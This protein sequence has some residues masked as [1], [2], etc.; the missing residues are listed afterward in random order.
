MHVS[1]SL[2]HGRSVGPSEQAEIWIRRSVF[3]EEL[4]PTYAG[5]L[6]YFTAPDGPP[7]AQVLAVNHAQAWLAEGITRLYIVEGVVTKYGG[8]FE[9]LIV[10]PAAASSLRIEVVFRLD[11]YEHSLVRVHGTV[12][13]A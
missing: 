11:D 12:P 8:R 10:G 6:D 3:G 13:V 7:L 5:S 2:G 1:F 4:D 9:Q